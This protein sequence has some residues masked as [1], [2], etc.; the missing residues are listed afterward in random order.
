MTITYHD[1]LI[2]GTEEWHAARCG[3][4][5]ASELHLIITPTLKVASN[6]KERAHLYE[7]LGQRITGYVEPHYI[8]DDMLRGWEDEI[9]A[10]ILY[11]EKYAPVLETGFITSDEYGFLIGYSPD[12]LVGK[13][14]LIECKSRR[15]KK[16]IETIVENEVPKENLIQVQTGLLVTG[17]IWCDYISYCA[18]L[19][20]FVKRV[21]A[22]DVMQK[23][24]IEAATNFE[25]RL[26][27]KMEN[28][29][30]FS[31]VFYPTERNI[32]DGSEIVL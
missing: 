16:Q 10:R 29:T 20:M 8:S 9:S 15:Q 22:D 12:G 11:S 24:I 6:D 31:S 25:E 2:Q 14:G 13:N 23:A 4:L 32:E 7:L 21:F 26:N 3:L 18:G 28:Y 17:R 27:E 19:P 1:D 30:K 5:C